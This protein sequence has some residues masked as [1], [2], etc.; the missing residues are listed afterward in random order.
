MA[1][2][3][4]LNFVTLCQFHSNTSPV[5]FTKFHWETIEWEK[6]RFFAY[7]AAS[8]Y[9]VTSKEVKNHI[10]IHNWIFRHTCCI[11]KP[12]WQISGI[13]I[14]LCKH[15]IVTSDTLVCSFL[16][17]LFLLLNVILSGLHEKSR[18]NKDW[19]TKKRT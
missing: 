18:S 1:F 10:M 4:P 9:H 15:Y 14:F 5:L 2:F 17:V 13:I 19:V 6:R 8:A 16:D 12:H 3:T 11:N 7:M